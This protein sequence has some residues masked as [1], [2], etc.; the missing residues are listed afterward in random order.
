MDELDEKLKDVYDKMDRQKDKILIQIEKS[1]HRSEKLVNEKL[2]ALKQLIDQS[3]TARSE[4]INTELARLRNCGTSCAENCA[5]FRCGYD[6]RLNTLE[7]WK[8]LNW[9]RTIIYAGVAVVAAVQVFDWLKG[10]I[11]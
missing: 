10:V 6:A 5:R 8:S 1:E 2:E 9:Q 7:N 4:Q 11:H 3:N